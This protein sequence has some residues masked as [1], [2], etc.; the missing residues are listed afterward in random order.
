MEYRGK[1]KLKYVFNKLYKGRN[2]HKM[3]ADN[4][5]NYQSRDWKI[6]LL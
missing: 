6:K 2:F 5:V 1:E 4:I 3:S